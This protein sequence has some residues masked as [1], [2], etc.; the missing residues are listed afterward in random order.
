MAASMSM[1]PID[2]KRAV[3]ERKSAVFNTLRNN[4]S[5]L[6]VA[7]RVKDNLK[8]W[9][10]GSRAGTGTDLE[11]SNRYGRSIGGIV[12]WFDN[13]HSAAL[14]TICQDD[15][16]LI[17]QLHYDVAR[18]A[19]FG[20]NTMTVHV[21]VSWR[22][23]DIEVVGY[24]GPLR[25]LMTREKLASA[26]R[27]GIP[28][29]D[30]VSKDSGWSKDAVRRLPDDLMSTL[31]NLLST[32]SIGQSKI[33]RLVKGFLLLLEVQERGA[34]G[35][36]VNTP[37]SI[38][39][40]PMAVLQ[41]FR[42]GDRAYVYNSKPDSEAHTMVLQLMSGAYP[43]P[44]YNSHISIPAD[45]TQIVMVSKGQLPNNGRPVTLTPQLVY[46]SLMTYAMDV[47]LT[48]DLQEAL[49]I[50]CSLQENRYFSKVRL[51]TVISV[52]DLMAPSFIPENSQLNRPFITTEMAKSLGR[53]HQMVHFCICKDIVGA[54]VMQTKAGFDPSAS[55]RTYLNSNSK[56]VSKMAEGMAGFDI[57]ASTASL[58]IHEEL[59]TVDYTDMLNLSIFEGLWLVN[60]ANRVVDNGIIAAIIDGE[61]LLTQ[62]R[63][64]YHVLREEL[65]IAGVD[66]EDSKMPNVAGQFTTTWVGTKS[67]I[68]NKKPKMRKRITVSAKLARECDFQPGMNLKAAGNKQRHGVMVREN[69]L[70]P[71]RAMSHRAQLSDKTEE[72][73]SY[74]SPSSSHLG[75]VTSI[76]ESEVTEEAVPVFS[77][78]TIAYEAKARLTKD[79]FSKLQAAIK[80]AAD[81][82]DKTTITTDHPQLIPDDYVKQIVN[83]EKFSLSVKE[84]DEWARLLL[85]HWDVVEGTDTLD[86][87]LGAILAGGK[88]TKFLLSG[89]NKYAKSYNMMV[90]NKFP[91]LAV[92]L[93]E[94]VRSQG[95]SWK[96][97]VSTLPKKSI[98]HIANSPAWTEWLTNFGINGSEM[99]G[100]GSERHNGKSKQSRYVI[101]DVLGKCGNLSLNDVGVIS[102]FLEDKR[103]NLM[104]K[105]TTRDMMEQNYAT[106]DWR[107][108]PTSL[109]PRNESKEDSQWLC[110]AARYSGLS[111]DI[112]VLKH[113]CGSFSVPW[114]IRQELKENYN[115]FNQ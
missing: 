39:Y 5:A 44:M 84:R 85:D 67:I 114:E 27:A 62:D 42:Q 108:E 31:Q 88:L 65:E 97:D 86:T 17:Y 72:L 92:S 106:L 26:A 1:G 104:P 83:K 115:L 79:S 61:R 64:S 73:P 69:I 103:Y 43:P 109:G 54:S 2:I 111:F 20:V 30:Q 41:S 13:H 21:A 98:I 80:T 55:I 71:S 4:A 7:R 50:A 15:F 32:V 25:T 59:T 18:I 89:N 49:L 35:M 10:P 57:V 93:E 70:K 48:G 6:N 77:P 28:D 81:K 75:P 82:L 95:S 101:A 19:V 56:L 33:T 66:I 113:L 53:I 60:S 37:L 105:Q 74:S 34:L 63:S 36:A 47:S 110:M 12:N 16:E 9:S 38:L 94:Q 90:M 3:Q 45:G 11:L 100:S 96:G 23:C 78:T 76:P 68:K 99:L 91:D 52:D 46:A 40:E 14:D 8:S 22:K 102:N 51:P 29:R 107:R 87:A 24:A 58:K 112:D